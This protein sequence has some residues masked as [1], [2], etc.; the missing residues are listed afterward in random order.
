MLSPRCLAVT[1]LA[2][3][4]GKPAGQGACGFTQVAGSSILLSQFGVPNQT[5]GTPPSEL[6]GRLVVRLVAGPAYPAITGRVESE[7]IVGLEGTLPP[8]VRPGSGVLVLDPGGRARGV[9]LF[10]SEAVKGAPRLGT[11]SIGAES[12]PLTGIQLD[13]T[14]FED[15][16]CP[17][18]PD[19]VL[20]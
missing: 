14:I 11:V 20:Q 1:L 4:C 6:P 17:F 5:L 18:F 13:P 9:V 16:Q 15:A 7:W 10:E 8:G 2:A 3:G 19:S 12:V